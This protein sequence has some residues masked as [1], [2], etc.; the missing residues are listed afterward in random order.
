MSAKNRRPRR[1]NQKKKT[2]NKQYK[3]NAETFFL[4]IFPR[5]I[6]L[7]T[8]I[9]APDLWRINVH[10]TFS[11]L[12]KDFN[13]KLCPFYL[14]FEIKHFGKFGDGF[15]DVHVDFVTSWNSLKRQTGF[16][17]L[18]VKQFREIYATFLCL[19]HEIASLDD[20]K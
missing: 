13:R 2:I 7:S 8:F 9:Q 20:F 11:F 19:Y 12:L 4:E 10:K 5:T 15:C 18:F 3:T 1:H 6:F 14:T 17:A 16:D